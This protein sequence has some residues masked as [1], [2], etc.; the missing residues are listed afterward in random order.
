MQ[1]HHVVVIVL[2]NVRAFHLETLHFGEIHTL[3]YMILR[4]TVQINVYLGLSFSIL[5]VF[6]FSKN[7]IVWDVSII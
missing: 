3:R 7:V 2:N 5:A 6:Q 4:P 1:E